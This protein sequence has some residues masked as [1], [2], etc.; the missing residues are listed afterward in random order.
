MRSSTRNVQRGKGGDGDDPKTILV[1]L[2]LSTM[3]R[4]CKKGGRI[5]SGIGL[6]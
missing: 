5:S 1:M 3:P 4:T 2:L 6:F